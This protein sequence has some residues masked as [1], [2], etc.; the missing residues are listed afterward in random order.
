[1][2]TNWPRRIPFRPGT[3][4]VLVVGLI[5]QQMLPSAF[6]QEITVEEAVTY[7][8]IDEVE[9]Q[10][11]IAYPKEA[12]CPYPTIVFIHGGGWSLGH[13]KTFRT[14]IQ[15]AAKRGYVGA[16]ISYR[17]TEPDPVT[18]L[19]KHPFPAQ[20]RDCKCAIRWLRSMADKY[21]IDKDRIGVT[22]NSAGGHLSLLIGMAAGEKSFE[23]DRVPDQPSTVKAVVNYYGPT[24]LVSEYNEAEKVREYLVP[25]CN[26]TP[27]TAAETYKR[28]SPLTYVTKQLPPI[29]TLHGEEDKLVPLSQAKKLDEAL[30]RAGAHHEMQTFPNMGHVIINDAAVK[31]GERMWAF[32]D[33]HVKGN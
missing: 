24:E 1:M 9:L 28:A 6:A 32:F 7:S 17:L 22:G 31:A 2:Q 25:L 26:G 12:K 5:A 8:K 21:H 15:T 4:A 13:R 33:R 11:D 16:T 30:K 23:D 3:L 20:I 19:G 29:L 14:A 18:K 10:L 27:E